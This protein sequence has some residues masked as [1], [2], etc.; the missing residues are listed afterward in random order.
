MEFAF[1]ISAVIVVGS[2]AYIV[3]LFRRDH[4]I[5]SQGRD[6]RVRVEDVRLVSTNDSGAATIKFRLSWHEDG[7]IRYAEGRDTI[8]AFHSSKVQKG[9]E[10]DIKYLDDGH[11]LFDFDK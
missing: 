6:I 1:I 5:R 7:V 11:I 2:T 10:V 8:S 9:C 3:H 4:K